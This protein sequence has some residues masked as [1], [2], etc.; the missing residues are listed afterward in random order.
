LL[1]FP[2]LLILI[3]L[4]L[5]KM[6]F[7]IVIIKDKIIDITSSFYWLFD[8]IDNPYIDPNDIPKRITVTLNVTNFLK[9][10]RFLGIPIFFHMIS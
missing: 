9:Y 2:E 1:V 7:I 10:N 5:D 8:T 4:L 6:T 3:I